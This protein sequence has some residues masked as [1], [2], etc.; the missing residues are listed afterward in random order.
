MAMN[1]DVGM[2][3]AKTR[4]LL[5]AQSCVTPLSELCREGLRIIVL[6]SLTVLLRTI[7]TILRMV[8]PYITIQNDFYT[9]FLLQKTHEHVSATPRVIERSKMAFCRLPYLH[10]IYLSSDGPF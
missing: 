3:H 9:T 7:V 2:H 10:D 4:N 1:G 6:V 5:L 8:H